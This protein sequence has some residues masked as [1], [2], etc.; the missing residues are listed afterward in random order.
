MVHRRC[1]ALLRDPEL[2]WDATQEVF[3]QVLRRQSALDIP[4]PSSYLYRVATNTSLNLLRARKRRPESPVDALVAEI[5]HAPDT[6]ARLSAA[7]LLDR[8]FAREPVS[9]RTLAVLHLVDGLTLDE[10]AGEVGLSV[11]GVRKRLR[12][13]R[14]NLPALE[15]V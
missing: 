10:V 15:A 1:L 2:A 13:L 12:T 9:T 3:V 5:A 4:A 7:T 11:S 14:E 8:V 6:E